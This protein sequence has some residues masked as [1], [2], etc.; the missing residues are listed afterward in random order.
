MVPASGLVGTWG[1]IGT[2][3]ARMLAD[4]SSSTRVCPERVHQYRSVS[5]AGVRDT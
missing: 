3:N 4:D 2:L 5:S 1:Q